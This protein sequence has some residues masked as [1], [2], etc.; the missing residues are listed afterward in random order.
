MLTIS[1]I[2]TPTDLSE[3][4]QDG[5][6]TAFEIANC[7]GAE[8]IIYHV[9]EHRGPMGYPAL[10]HDECT[11]HMDL[12]KEHKKLLATFF[13]ANFADFAPGV[14]VI[15]EVELGVPYR[16]ILDRAEEAGADLIVM[17]TH[18]RTGLLYGL[19][20]SVAETVVRLASC[21]VLS[22]HPIKRS[23]EMRTQAA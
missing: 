19:I 3:L 5:I 22:I 23:H 10:F 14:K 6:R 20:G 15:Q 2:L 7:T 8:V 17:S 11:T 21:P 9:I 16:K 4:S 1:K 12:I 13:D 18:G